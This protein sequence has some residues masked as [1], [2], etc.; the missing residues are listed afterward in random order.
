MSLP[1]ITAPTF[2]VDVKSLNKTIKM[3]PFLVKEE[4]IL[5]LA[6]ETDDVAEIAN[7]MRQVIS[8]CC[9]DELDVDALPYFDLQNIFIRLR[10]QS[11]GSI[12]DFTLI[13]GQCSHRT[14]T[15]LDLNQIQIKETDGHTNKIDIDQGIGV[16]MKYPRMES[17][18]NEKKPIY[19]LV[20]ESIDKIYNDEEI[21]D[22]KEY[23]TDEL[24]SFVDNLSNAH[25]AKIVEFFETAP[26]VQH[27]IEYKCANCETENVVLV[28]GVQNFFG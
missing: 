28:D 1:T 4:K 7:V 21:F 18:V 12:T 13:C 19:D 15:Q 26:K 25:F 11:I 22:V 17:L 5:L 16:I 3:R 9:L 20:V 10:E 2:T 6:S 24:K 23:T 27:L 14:P 8:A